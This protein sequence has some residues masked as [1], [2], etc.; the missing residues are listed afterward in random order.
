MKR[1]AVFDHTYCCNRLLWVVV[2]IEVDLYLLGYHTY[3]SR[4]GNRLLLKSP[5]G[6]PGGAAAWSDKPE[7]EQVLKPYAVVV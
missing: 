3:C 6:R 7:H 1:G 2:D 5:T 4:F